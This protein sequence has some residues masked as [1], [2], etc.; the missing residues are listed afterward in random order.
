MRKQ[1]QKKQLE[2][3]IANVSVMDIGDVIAKMVAYSR[4]LKREQHRGA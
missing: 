1:S 4:R 3:Q 2:S